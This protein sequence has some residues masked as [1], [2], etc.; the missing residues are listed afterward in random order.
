[1]EAVKVNLNSLSP[2]FLIALK[3]KLSKAESVA[4]CLWRI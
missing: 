4:V 2:R 1:M 3:D